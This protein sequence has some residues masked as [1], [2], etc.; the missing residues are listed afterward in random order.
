MA[1]VEAARMPQVAGVRPHRR[2]HIRAL[3]Q[4]SLEHTLLRV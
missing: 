1:R 3:R 4:R 2:A